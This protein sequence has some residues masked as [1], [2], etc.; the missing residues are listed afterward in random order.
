[1]LTK[2]FTAILLA[3][4]L[5][6]TLP[7]VADDKTSIPEKDAA[8]ANKIHT[9]T[10]KDGRVERIYVEGCIKC[11]LRLT[12]DDKTLFIYNGKIIKQNQ[13]K[14]YSH[15]PATAVYEIKNKHATKVIW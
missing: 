3:G 4:S 11:P 12:T 1:M 6:A 14:L 13:I 10:D 9:F 7:V 8:E 5:F 2:T 15:L